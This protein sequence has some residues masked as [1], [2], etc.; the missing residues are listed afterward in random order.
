MEG[1]ESS[2][3]ESVGGQEVTHESAELEE[4]WSDDE[5]IRYTLPGLLIQPATSQV[6]VI[7]S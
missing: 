3:E 6:V 7:S 5:S 2:G 1:S 4:D